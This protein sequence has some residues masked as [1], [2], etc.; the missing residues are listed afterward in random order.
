MWLRF[1]LR[2]NDRLRHLFLLLVIDEG[3]ALDGY[4][5][6]RLIVLHLSFL[7]LLSALFQD[8]G[9]LDVHLLSGLLCLKILSEC[10]FNFRHQLFRHLCVW[11]GINLNP[12]PLQEIHKVG[13]ADVEL[14]HDFVQS[15]FCHK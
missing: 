14:P 6:F 8:F 1:R 7:L 12:L 3:V 11:I 15:D 5:L 4:D 10:L 9:N 13:E 2:H